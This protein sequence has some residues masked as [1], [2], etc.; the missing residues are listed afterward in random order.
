MIF[1]FPIEMSPHLNISWPISLDL[2]PLLLKDF[3]YIIFTQF[4]LNLQLNSLANE[5]KFHRLYCYEI[6]PCKVSHKE[7]I[8]NG[9]HDIDNP[10]SST[11]RIL[12]WLKIKHLGS[13]IKDYD[14]VSKFEI[15]EI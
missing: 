6:H 4:V 7:S 15:I 9:E 5:P 12:N 10:Q 8:L 2:I 1:L 3:L 14:V 11:F 13:Y